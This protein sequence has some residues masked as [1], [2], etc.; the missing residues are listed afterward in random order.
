MDVQARETLGP[1]RALV[2]RWASATASRL[3]KPVNR[4]DDGARK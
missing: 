1:D 3:D 2:F 4:S